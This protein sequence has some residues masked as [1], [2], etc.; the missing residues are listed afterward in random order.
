MATG[1]PKG[2]KLRVAVV[3]G[4]RSAEHE[5]SLLSARFVVESLDRERFEPVLIG[6]DKSGRWLAQRE[7][8]LLGQARDPRLVALDAAA[9]EAQLAPFPA[10]PDAAAGLTTTH[11]ATLEVIGSG[12]QSIDVVFPVLHG[13]MG[14]DGTVQGL[15]TLA[16]VPFVGSGV[17][18]SA[19][20]MDKDVMK[21]LLRDAGLPI[22]P[23]VTLKRPR[24]DRARAAVVDELLA[25][26]KGGPVF[27]KPANLGSSVGVSR[28][29]SRAEIAAAA[30][31]AF[32]FDDKIV[33]EPGV[34]GLREL[35]C[36]VLGGELPIASRVG[37]IKVTHPDGF[38]SYAAK[39]VDEHG[40]TTL[41]PA[42]ISAEEEAHVQR[43][44]LATFEALE[45]FGLARVDLFRAGDGALY[46]NEVNTMP[47][48]TAISMY[49]KLLEASGVG[50]RELVSRLID[51]ALERAAA[52]KRLRTS[53]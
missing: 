29:V 31:L 10:A 24:W 16:D 50:A 52:R 34:S 21:R 28:A 14:E 42:E 47:G 36:A 23:F 22:V 44:A 48:F 39:Y 38:Y 12:A 26:G 19:V 25:L 49:P 37:E 35:E 8:A 1:A 18:G 41:V 15:L 51:L 4:G 33:V 40:A 6:I 3:F 46:V 45:C 9:P 11:T 2:K 43:L 30:D 27:V 20:G 32:S 17:L 53:T 5:I 7:A 13:P